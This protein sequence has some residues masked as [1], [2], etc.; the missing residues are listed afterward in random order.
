MRLAVIS[1][2]HGNLPALE[3]VLADIDSHAPD[4]TVNLGDCVTSPLWP[5]ETLELLESLALPSV[6][7]NHDR[8]VAER[9]RDDMKGS[10]A[11][12]HDA[13]SAAQRSALGAL[14]ATLHLEPGILA[15][16]GTPG[17]DSEYLLEE[18]VDGRLALA[19]RETIAR[20]LGNAANGA[21]LVLCGH[22]HHQHSASAPGGLL[23]LN[24]G[25][26]GCPRYADNEDPYIAEAGSP[27]ARYAVV[28]RRA[29]R[30]SIEMKA[31][32]YD[33]DAVRQRAVTNGRKDWADGFLQ[34][35]T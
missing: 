14:P 4:A 23:V 27:H 1:D 2:V 17:N 19:R 24:P 8:W 26:V 35:P 10:M 34:Q 22:S 7:G 11:F 25:S 12:T 28:T 29:Q 18:A 3:T 30:W 15:V 31:I 16:H 6:R 20:R 32:E 5:R 13:L 9:A 33:W 21:T